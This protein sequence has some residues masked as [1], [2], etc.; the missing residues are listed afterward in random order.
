MFFKES[1]ILFLKLNVLFRLDLK[2][3]VGKYFY[4]QLSCYDVELCVNF[5]TSMTAFRFRFVWGK[6][7][8]Y[9]SNYITNK[10]G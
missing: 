1:L 7:K 6:K 4:L 8:L 5:R 9:I 3:S 2:C 10:R